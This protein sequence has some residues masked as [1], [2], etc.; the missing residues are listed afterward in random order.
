MSSPVENTM[1]YKVHDFQSP[2]GKKILRRWKLTERDLIRAVQAWE[3]ETGETIIT[4]FGI[5]AAGFFGTPDPNWKIG[6]E[7]VIIP[8]AQIVELLGGRPT[9]H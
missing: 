1:S 2:A 5:T 6:D 7:V 8:Y 3:K 4:A 9:S